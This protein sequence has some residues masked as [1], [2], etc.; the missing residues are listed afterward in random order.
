ML[1]VG[2]IV[3]DDLTGLCSIVERA[4]YSTHNPKDNYIVLQDKSVNDGYRLECQLECVEPK[5]EQD[6]LWE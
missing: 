3:F 5:S 4:L 6:G 2:D 1:K